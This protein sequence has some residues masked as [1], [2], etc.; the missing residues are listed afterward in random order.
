MSRN[1]LVHI[2]SISLLLLY[3]SS[4]PEPVWARTAED[5]ES[6][7]KEANGALRQQLLWP[8]CSTAWVTLRP[9]A[10]SP[11]SVI[12]HQRIQYEGTWSRGD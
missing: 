4:R 7:V 6:I 12:P 8:P 2:R 1:W 3:T 10:G 11:P 9:S 5:A